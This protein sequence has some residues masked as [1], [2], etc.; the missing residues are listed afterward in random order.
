M[1]TQTFEQW[2]EANYHESTHPGWYEDN[3]NYPMYNMDMLKKK[4]ED[5]NENERL[6]EEVI[7]L[8]KLLEK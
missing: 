7:S 6:K 2:L 1:P 4:Y 3:D 8:N 5:L